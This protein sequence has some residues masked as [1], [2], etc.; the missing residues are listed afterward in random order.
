MAR[1]VGHV[2]VKYGEFNGDPS[3]LGKP[4]LAFGEKSLVDTPTTG[5]YFDH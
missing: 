1:S 2:E 4:R 5:M 3:D